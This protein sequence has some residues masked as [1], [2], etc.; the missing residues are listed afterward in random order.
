MFRAVLDSQSNTADA[1]GNGSETLQTT[2]AVDGGT[3]VDTLSITATGNTANAATP[4][5]VS[6]VEKVLV[7]NLGTGVAATGVTTL[8]LASVTGLQEVINDGSTNGVALQNIGSAAVT[9]KN[10]TTA[11]TTT[12]TRGTAPVTTDLTVNLE[13]VGK[14]ATAADATGTLATQM[15]ALSSVSAN[16]ASTKAT[17]NAKGYVNVVSAELSGNAGAGHTIDTLTINADGQTIFGAAGGGADITGFD[18]AKSAKIVVTGAGNVALNTLAAVVQTVDASAN[19]GGVTLAGT[20][21]AAP[22]TNAAALAAP[23]L[24]LTGGSGN[25]S[26]TFDGVAT[27]VVDLGA[28]NDTAI[29]NA[30]LTA[31]ASIKG[32]EGTDTVQL[33]V[34]DINALE[35]QTAAGTA[36]RATISGFEKLGVTGDLTAAINAARAGGYNYVVLN[37]AVDNADA[38]PVADQSVNISGLTTG[39]TVEFRALGVNEDIAEVVMTDAALATNDVLNIVLNANLATGTGSQVTAK[40]GVAGINNI[41][42]TA[43]DR[44]ND[45]TDDD[46]TTAALGDNGADDGYTVV[47]SNGAN[48][49]TVTVAG[50]SAV[51]Y[52]LSAGTD[53]VTL[54]DA[55][56]STGN[57]TT[58]VAA[59]AGTQRVE[60]KGSQGVNDITGSGLA[61]GEKITGGAKGDIITGDAGADD[62]TG[63]GGRDA[64]V[65]GAGAS[66]TTATTVDQI[67]D[68]GK[69]TVAATGAEVTGMG[70]ANDAAVIAAFQAA[71]TARGGDNADLLA[72]NAVAATSVATA[73][74]AADDAAINTALEALDLSDA[75]QWA[76]KVVNAT[77]AKGMLTVGGAN[78]ADIDTLAEWVAV[79]NVAAETAGETVAFAFNG[80]TYVFQ[81]QVA[82]DELVEL[83]GTTGVTGVVLVGG[84]VAAAAGDIFIV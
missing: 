53:A 58:S 1:T 83:T 35:A 32:G 50:T 44:V 36:L 47:L 61:F 25:D 48:V 39:A 62:M 21:Y 23:G 9:V 66:G 82:G 84:A 40:V 33:V 54:I 26:F 31:G 59:F 64:F 70:G 10:V 41:N 46:E 74:S 57:F 28:G 72:F 79:A 20:Q 51:T 17:I 29:V 11:Q 8:N 13:N 67:S 19:T 3:G 49:N 45:V 14:A 4:L 81:Q 63:N 38:G 56:A 18:L 76:G 37:G 77:I 2:D 73:K 30:G 65:Q 34:A 7:K 75:T 71:A 5:F 68:F 52:A 22:G 6:S 55:S 12:F 60:I 80:N 69:V 43:N 24:K 78:A 27:A 15:G 42:I 16:N